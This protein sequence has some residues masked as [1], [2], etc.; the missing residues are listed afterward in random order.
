MVSDISKGNILTLIETNVKLNSHWINGKVEVE[1]LDFYNLNYSEKMTSLIEK[2]NVIIAADG[3]V[4]LCYIHCLL[5]PII[6][7]ILYLQLCT[8]MILLILF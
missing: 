8:M 1:E 7:F 4:I 5:Q 3:M 6:I 2:A